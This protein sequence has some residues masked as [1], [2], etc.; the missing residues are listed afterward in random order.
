[1][2]TGLLTEFVSCATSAD[3]NVDDNDGV[4]ET[5]N[6][7]DDDGIDGKRELAEDVEDPCVV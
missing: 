1:M 2:G 5:Q 4:G 7:C 3:C 6:E